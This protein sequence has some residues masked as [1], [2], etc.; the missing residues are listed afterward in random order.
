MIHQLPPKPDYLRVKVRRRL[1]R[2]GAVAIKNTVY[3]LPE[4]EQQAEDF[5]WLAKEIESD[6]GEAYLCK[7]GFIAGLTDDAVVR[8]FNSARD[9]DYGNVAQ[10]L[11]ELLAEVCATPQNDESIVKRRTEVRRLQQAV[12]EIAAIDFFAADG[13]AACLAVIEQLEARIVAQEKPSTAGSVPGEFRGRTWVTR[14][15]IFVDRMASAWLIRRYIDPEA[16]FRFVEPGTYRHEPD[17]LRFDMFE[18][19]YTH[20]GERCTFEVL[21]DS[22]AVDVPG[23]AVIAE[24]VH[25]IDLKDALFNRPETA[26]VQA[27]L[28]GIRAGNATDDLRLQ[29][30]MALFDALRIQ[31]AAGGNSRG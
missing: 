3:A 15:N 25:D 16:R 27:V 17:E 11:H 1:Q 4:R 31:L 24:I 7:A 12:E 18:G 10:N 9:E 22:F 30:G 13:R 26:G 28:A 2:I 23:V 19:E 14:A 20:I 8:L 29:Q 21:L 6:G 5:A